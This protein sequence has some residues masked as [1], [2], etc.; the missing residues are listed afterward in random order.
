MR[1]EKSAVAPEV[2]EFLTEFA[3]Y[4]LAAGISSI[5]FSRIAQMAF[6]KA[7]SPGARFSNSRINQSVV[8]AI[9]GLSRVQVR[10]LLRAETKKIQTTDD[11][12]DKVLGAWTAEAEFLTATGEPKRLKISGNRSSFAR[13]VRRFDKDV[14]PNAFLRALLRRR[15]V[16]INRDYVSLTASARNK[17]ELRRLGQIS[18][19]LALVLRS[20]VADIP[21][22]SIKV[23]NFEVTH[24]TPALVGRM[25]LQ[26]RISKSLKAFMADIEAASSAVA[27]ESPAIG[28]QGGGISKTSVLLISQD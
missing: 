18:T 7:A 12:I 11:K 16:R 28:S 17:R 27:L 5:Q 25:L 21:A 26:R 23:A 8:A 3:R 1:Q 10:S 9:T 14:P 24:D 22:R 20:P 4:L 15:L 19:A 6:L 2:V 13:L